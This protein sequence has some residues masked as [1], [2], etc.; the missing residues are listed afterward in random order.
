MP[1]AE[2]ARVLLGH[3]SGGRL[4]AELI[5]D[6]L[7]PALGTA[8]PAGPL[9]D[10]ALLGADLAV[11][12]D[13]YVVDPLFFPGGDI[14][15]LAVHGTVNDLAMRAAMPLA[16]TL[17]YV[18]EGF[19][20]AD[21]RRVAESVGAAARAAGV[22]VIA[23]DTKVV[24]RGAADGLFL[25]SSGVGRRLPG[26]VASAAGARPGDAVLLSGPIGAH[27]MAVL[28]VREGLDFDTDIRSDSRPLHRLVAA[29]HDAGGGA[30][31]TLRDATRGGLASVLNEIAA[32]SGVGVEVRE[33][34]LPVS[35]PV[36]A[37]C[38]LLGLDPVHV[39]NEGCLVAFVAP[40]RADPVLAA[41]RARPEGREAVRI[42]TVTP[43][44]PV[45]LRT[46]VGSH[47]VLDMLVGEQLPR[48]C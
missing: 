46:M 45:V 47:R 30:V 42:G 9:E 1:R 40:E 43:D 36:R 22:P 23:A 15:A 39:A 17:A 14:G 28:S 38:E 7:L 35:G 48:I 2:T 5:A 32:A 41:M 12:T 18:I 24:D 6:V 34:A 13:A 8:A 4:S 44:G 19:P 29:V 33:R 27:G 26:A 37:A 25:I 31:H 21:L 3:G 11:S 16:L 20:V 10:A